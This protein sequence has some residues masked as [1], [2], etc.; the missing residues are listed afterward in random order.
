M[1]GKLIGW[2]KVVRLLPWWNISIRG[3]GLG[4]ENGDVHQVGAFADG[5]WVLSQ[6]ASD[7][8]ELAGDSIAFSCLECVIT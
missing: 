6:C 1:G 7:V 2:W 3:G 4:W 8:V 5:R